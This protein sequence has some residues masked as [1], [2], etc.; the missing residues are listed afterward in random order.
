MGGDNAVVEI[1]LLQ[2]VRVRIILLRDLCAEEGCGVAKNV[3]CVRAYVAERG[4]GY[5][6]PLRFMFLLIY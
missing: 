1:A 2:S 3:F 6:E 4:V 5:Y